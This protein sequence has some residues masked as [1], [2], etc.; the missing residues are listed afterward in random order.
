M[1]GMDKKVSRARILTPFWR[2]LRAILL[3]GGG[4]RFCYTRASRWAGDYLGVWYFV[5][6]VSKETL[7]QKKVPFVPVGSLCIK[8]VP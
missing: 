5:F 4:W 2:R 7:L 8:G 6:M 3:Q 1:C